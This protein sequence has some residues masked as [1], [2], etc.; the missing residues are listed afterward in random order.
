MSVA[1]R[2]AR[3]HVNTFTDE[4]EILQDRRD[5]LDLQECEAF[6]QLGIDAFA[7]LLRADEAIRAAVY[8]GMPHDPR[9][10]EAIRELLVAWLRPC[11]RANQWVQSLPEA[12]A[13]ANLAEFRRCEREALAIV[14]S[15]QVDELTEAMRQM[16][17]RA[18]AEHERG[19]TAEF[20]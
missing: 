17:D 16:R 1:L 7:W 8:A 18:L 14:K 13:P 5:D 6:L 11:A 9:F 19:E 3:R 4:S 2:A 12:A 15:W 10:D 20:I